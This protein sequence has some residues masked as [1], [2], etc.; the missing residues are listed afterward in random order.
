MDN[1]EQQM[2][3]AIR[4]IA[5]V[6]SAGLLG[7]LTPFIFNRLMAIWS[8]GGATAN[9]ATT[10]EQQAKDKDVFQK[11][12]KDAVA[13]IL[14]DETFTKAISKDFTR[15]IGAMDATLA[16][17]LSQLENHMLANESQITK[18]GS[19]IEAFGQNTKTR[20]EAIEGMVSHIT[21]S[22]NLLGDHVKEVQTKVAS[23]EDTLLSAQTSKLDE[24]MSEVKALK[25]GPTAVSATMSTHAT[26]LEGISAKL[27]SIKDQ[28]SA[29]DTSFLSTHSTKLDDIAAT[30]SSLKANAEVKEALS[31]ILREVNKIKTDVESGSTF[32]TS[33]LSSLSDQLGI[34]LGAIEKQST[35]DLSTEILAGVQRSNVAHDTHTTA[36]A[37]IKTVNDATAPALIDLQTQLDK[38]T[39]ILSTIKAA[40]TSAEILA[41]VKSSNESH[42]ALTTVLSEI[43]TATSNA[44]PIDLSIIESQ[45]KEISITLDA[46]DN[47]LC[48]IKTISD[49]TEIKSTLS[50]HGTTLAEIKKANSSSSDIAA[51]KATT[52]ENK[53]VLA[54]IMSAEVVGQVREIKRLIQ[55]PR[56]TVTDTEVLKTLNSLHSILQ[57]GVR[58]AADAEIVA[59]VRAIHSSLSSGVTLSNKTMGKLKEVVG[60]EVKELDIEH[61]K[62]DAEM[63]NGV[64]G[65]RENGVGTE[66]VEVAAE[67]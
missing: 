45:I 64:V 37:D 50:T 41:G 56:N 13:A 9:K 36:L 53:A 17:I 52:L 57:S 42:A 49:N 12:L 19:D 30:L 31:T 43:K 63:G 66:A 55:N 8:R 20:L 54:K 2:S 29:Q 4:Q 21:T 60:V 1:Y 7:A 26:K 39:N 11:S 59:D 62:E 33:E 27:T 34:V 48:D 51:I 40:D 14:T 23:R 15:Q 24:I 6:A 3:S 22:L 65:E 5:S 46:Y 44:N 10:D 58:L 28:I 61:V 25:E 38:L 35:D 16:N 18:H 47:T 67:S 32:F